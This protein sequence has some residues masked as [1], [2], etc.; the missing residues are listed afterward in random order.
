[1]LCIDRVHTNIVEVIDEMM[2]E[3]DAEEVMEEDVEEVIEE[4]VEEVIEE[5]IEEE[6]DTEEEG[7]SLS[8]LSQ[9]QLNSAIY[10]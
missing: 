1:M 3:G 4:D 7:I 8:L 5:V 10:G 6:E 9:A 2:E